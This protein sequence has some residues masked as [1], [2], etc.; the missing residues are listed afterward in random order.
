MGIILKNIPLTLAEFKKYYQALRTKLEQIEYLTVHKLNF[1]KELKEN[2]KNEG[3]NNALLQVMI[4]FAENEIK[5]LGG[6]YSPIGIPIPPDS[7]KKALIETLEEKYKDRWE[8]EV[9]SQ[10]ELIKS[11]ELLN[12]EKIDH[13]PEESNLIKRGA[14]GEIDN[15]FEASA[16]YSL[17]QKA[18][19]GWEIKWSKTGKSFSLNKAQVPEKT[20]NFLDNWWILP[21]F[22]LL[23]YLFWLGNHYVQKNRIET[24]TRDPIDKSQKIVLEKEQ[25]KLKTKTSTLRPS[26]TLERSKSVQEIENEKTSSILQTN[27]K[28]SLNVLSVPPFKK[29]RI[30]NIIPE[31]KQGI[32][33]DPGIYQL[34]VKC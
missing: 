6:P 26:P 15:D 25:K 19:I 10:Q 3:N 16:Y 18:P 9:E 14:A 21:V 24:S 11:N 1:Q 8:K 31:F 33:L 29:V 22:L 34:E 12:K 17:T 20:K 2:K 27:G 5:N 30:L 32:K 28:Y 4:N 7:E 23:I 13:D